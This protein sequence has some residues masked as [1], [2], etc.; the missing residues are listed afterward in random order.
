M[1]VFHMLHMT[2][3]ATY[4]VHFRLRR[5]RLIEHFCIV[6]LVARSPWEG[7]IDVPSHVARLMTTAAR[8]NLIPVLIGRTIDTRADAN[9]VQVNSMKLRVAP[10]I[11][12]I[13]IGVVIL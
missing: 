11:R 10:F 4:S 6:T 7:T 9:T 12:I 5:S 3:G 1:R 8:E 2:G 13:L